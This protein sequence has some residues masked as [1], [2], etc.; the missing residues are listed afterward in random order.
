[1]R[2]SLYGMEHCVSLCAVC[3]YGLGVRWWA[4]CLPWIRNS[5]HLKTPS[6][7]FLNR[8]QVQKLNVNAY[9]KA[10]P[11]LGMFL[12]RFFYVF[13][14]ISRSKITEN[15]VWLFGRLLIRYIMLKNGPLWF[16][17]KRD[18]SILPPYSVSFSFVFFLTVTGAETRPDSSGFALPPTPI[19]AL[20][21]SS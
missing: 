19:D 12:D 5:W 3:I 1:M 13:E 6:K 7:M 18:P 2:V 10:T 8:E 15:I 9:H 21:G 17:G 16:P 4:S 11:K 20:N 14:T